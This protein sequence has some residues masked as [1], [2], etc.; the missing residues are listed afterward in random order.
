M[1]NIEN[2]IKIQIKIF[3]KFKKSMNLIKKSC[4]QLYWNLIVICHISVVVVVNKWWDYWFQIIFAFNNSTFHFLTGKVV[5]AVYYF[6]GRGLK[7]LWRQ[8]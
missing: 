3:C 5:E 4:I 2:W 7:I 8:F 6:E 1:L